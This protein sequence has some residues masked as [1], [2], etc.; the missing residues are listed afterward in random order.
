MASK[1]SPISVLATLSITA[2]AAAFAAKAGEQT[3][4]SVPL[5]RPLEDTDF[6]YDGAPA[7]SLV[8]LGRNLFFDPVLS[9]NGNISCGTCH[10]PA[11]GSGDGLALGIGEGGV[12]A[13]PDRATADPVTGRVPRNAQP[14]WNIGA[15]GYVSMFHDG[16]VEALD[17]SHT[18]LAIR[19]PAGRDLP[20]NISGVLTAQ[21]FFPV[22]SPIEMAG[23]YGENPIADAAHH[24]DRPAIWNKLAQRVAAHTSY[25][26]MMQFAFPEITSPDQVTYSHIAEALAAFQT[27]AFRSDQSQFDS[28]MRTG[29][30][31]ILTPAAQNGA[32]LFYGKAKCAD[33]HSGPLLTDHQFHAI[34]VPQI[35]PGKGHGGDMTYLRTTGLPARTED[36]GRY[37]VTGDPADLFAFRTPSLRNVELTGPWGHSG[38]FDKLEDMVRH[39]LDPQTSLTAF[40][41]AEVLLPPL[42]SLQRLKSR[43]SGLSFAPLE[44]G[45]RAAFDRRDSWV[46]RSS[47]LRQRIA[48]ANVLTPIALT[49]EEIRDLV[50]FLETLTDPSA[51]DRSEMIPIHL[52]SGLPPQ[53]AAAVS[54]QHVSETE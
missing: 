20:N 17:A 45:R 52:P 54:N 44:A 7:P 9:G 2:L 24:E 10:D 11:L 18:T 32:D 37:R 8:E 29:E 41:P 36:E 6:L 43:G 5:P 47:D 46:M 33:C 53:P 30:L 25:F 51:L 34:A 50:S 1:M 35:G 12:G 28:V 16:R 26:E 40:D 49:E 14:L 4:L 38:A 3:Q 31:S 13:G 22:T 23:Q 39:H 42:A 27:V 15:R 21:A 48:L 19:N